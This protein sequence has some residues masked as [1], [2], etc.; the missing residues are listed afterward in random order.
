MARFVVLTS[1]FGPTPAVRRFAEQAPDRV[2]VVGDRKTPAGWSCPGVEYLSADAQ[3][4]SGWLTAGALPWN[5]YARKM[6]GYLRALERGADT[7]AESDDDNLPSDGWSFPPFQGTF[8]EV[9]AGPHYNVYSRFTDRRVWPRG[10]PL[11]H[12]RE[13]AE[14]EESP[15]DCRVAVWQGLVDGDPDVDAIY[16]LTVGSPVSF[17]DGE[18]AVLAP[19]TVCPFNSQNTLFRR[20]A[21]PLLYLP[22]TVSVRAT[23]IV[24]GLVAQPVLWAAGMRLGFVG[25]NARQERNPHD[26]LRDFEDEI[27]L[28][29]GAEAVS[30][31][32]AAAVSAEASVEENLRRAYRRLAERALV[33]TEELSLLD[34]WLGDVASLNGGG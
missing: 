3:A 24:R 31:A 14:V 7:I 17:N 20:E 19:G 1:V 8:P 10:F 25:A 11:S 15:R 26:L 28:Y 34:A 6:V 16:R 30:E 12:V 13:P 29:L 9:A 22:A 33:G 32:A 2:I 21:F 18:P 4:A 5:H 23:D 27:P